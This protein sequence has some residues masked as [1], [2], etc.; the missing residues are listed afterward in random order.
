M[1]A[2][3]S[4]GCSW[5]TSSA[6]TPSL[7]VTVNI[8]MSLAIDHLGWFGLPPHSMN[9]WRGIGAALL[10]GGITPHQPLLGVRA[11]PHVPGVRS[12]GSSGLARC[13]ELLA[14]R[15]ARALGP[16]LNVFLVTQQ[17]MCQSS[18]GVPDGAKVP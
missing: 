3:S 8:V 15:R 7:A 16:C 13:A 2:P 10:A 5:S 9:T 4:P 17:H 14:G 11:T 1:P 12:A 6:P 18:V